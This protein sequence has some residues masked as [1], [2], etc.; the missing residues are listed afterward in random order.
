MGLQLRRL[1]KFSQDISDCV[2]LVLFLVYL[3]THGAENKN[4][5]VSTI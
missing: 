3:C 2:S 5:D 1:N 4:R